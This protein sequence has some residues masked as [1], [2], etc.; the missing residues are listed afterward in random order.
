MSGLESV[1]G[2]VKG[3]RHVA[4]E[5]SFVLESD[6]GYWVCEVLSGEVNIGHTI[7]GE[8]IA[9]DL[10]GDSGVSAHNRTTGQPIIVYV[11]FFG[12]RAVATI[13][14]AFGARDPGRPRRV[15]GLQEV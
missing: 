3:I 9:D 12:G 11:R 1:T 10:E 7:S 4:G 5:E 13:N 2:T 15:S 8:F 6:V 14:L